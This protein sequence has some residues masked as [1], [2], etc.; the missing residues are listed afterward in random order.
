MT[1]KPHWPPFS[2][3]LS[4]AASPGPD[5]PEFEYTYSG[6]YS[7]VQQIYEDAQ[8]RA[9][10]ENARMPALRSA[11]VGRV[12]VDW[13]RSQGTG[14]PNRACLRVAKECI[15]IR[16]SILDVASCTTF[17]LDLELEHPGHRGWVP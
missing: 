3:G 9:P 16:S 5:G 10:P 8:V 1:P 13:L 7:A 4:M 12:G 14:S 15:C 17:H 6:N 11:H 2:G